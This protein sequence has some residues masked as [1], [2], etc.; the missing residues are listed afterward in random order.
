MNLEESKQFLREHGIDPEEVAEDGKRY[1]EALKK[2]AEAVSQ[3]EPIAVV[4][5]REKALR[6]V[7]TLNRIG[8]AGIMPDGKIV[9]KRNHDEAQ[10]IPENK[11]LGIAKPS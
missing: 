10:D 4:R 2:Y 6:E 8:N 7:L 11:S 5:A 9:D 1:G 3:N